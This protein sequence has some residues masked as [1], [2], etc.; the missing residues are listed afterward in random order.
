MDHLPVDQLVA[1]FGPSS[2][3]LPRRASLWVFGARVTCVASGDDS[4]GAYEFFEHLVP[5][6]GGPPFHCHQH[7]SEGFYVAQGQFHFQLGD[8][9]FCGSAGQF[10]VFPKGI[11][12]LYRNVDKDWG[13]LFCIVTPAGQ[14][15]F[16]NEIGQ[17]SRQEPLDLSLIL[18]TGLRHGIT[19]LTPRSITS[20]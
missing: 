8:K 18:E 6:G 3:P 5:P 17:I 1:A 9:S 10:F 16:F 11:P 15:K 20:D 4:G 14:D 2:Q 12:H 19:I 13:R 7:E